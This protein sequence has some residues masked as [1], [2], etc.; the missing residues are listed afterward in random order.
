MS[1][2]APPPDGSIDE[3]GPVRAP[4]LAGGAAW[5]NVD[6][7]LTLS[8]LRGKVV[9]LDFWTYGCINCLHQLPGLARL[10][11][12]YADELVVVGVHAPK[13]TNE[14]D[15]DNLRR[16]L[17]RYEITHPVVSDPDY[18]IWRAYTVRA[19]P[20]LVLIDPAGYLVAGAS[21]EGHL[22]QFDRAIAAVIQVF[23]ERGEL[24]RGRRVGRDRTAT[25]VAT[26]SLAF[27]GGLAC[28]LPRDRLYV[29][30]SN[31]HQVLVST[32]DGAV[33]GRLGSGQPSAADG[34]A[35]GCGFRRPQGVAVQP[36]DGLVFVADTG[37]HLIR[38]ADPVHGTVATIAGTGAQGRPGDRGG[39]ADATALSSPWDLHPVGRLLLIAMAG[40]HQLWALDVSQG[41]VFA[42]AGSGR[43]A[44]QDGDLDESA[45]AQP[46]GLAGAAGVV[47]VAD[48]ESNVIRQ[49]DLPPRNRVRTLAG[50]D[51]FEFGDEVGA[52]DGARFQHPLGVT[53]LEGRLFVADTYN[54]RIKWLDPSTGEVGHLAGSGRPGFDD[55]DAGTASFHEPAGL[56]AGAGRVYV[57]DTNNHAVRGVDVSTGRVETLIAG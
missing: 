2:P 15:P 20:T 13:F 50:G 30:D 1:D 45:F 18:A 42:F 54:H 32:T 39:A 46:S 48:S 27:P 52:G 8:D 21:G 10:A 11:E 17:D 34:D 23:D 12:A 37:N 49:L 9:L 33:V 43:E 25:S 53:W 22:S 31:H 47:W 3:A 29:T 28:D 5:L 51:L 14:R 4:E 26:G 56:A 6:A 44:R 38:A 40:V 35:G 55:G 36:A 57:A 24:D 7:P 41:L 19:W 16:I